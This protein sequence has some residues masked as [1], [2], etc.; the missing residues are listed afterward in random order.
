MLSYVYYLF[1]Y[2]EEVQA[3]E[4]SKRQKHLVL[5]QI[6]QSKLKLKSIKPVAVQPFL[7]RKK[8]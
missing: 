1:G 6:L 7:K 5:Q 2:Q 8:V 4:N 3:D